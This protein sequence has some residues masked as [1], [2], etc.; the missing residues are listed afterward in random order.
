MRRFLLSQKR[1][2]KDEP[3]WLAYR[4]SMNKYF[5]KGYARNVPPGKLGGDQYFQPHF[6]V[7]KLGARKKLRIVFDAAS[8]YRGVSM[9]DRQVS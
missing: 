2:V 5:D 8:I 6:A 4:P 3:H 7:T 9:N 1:F